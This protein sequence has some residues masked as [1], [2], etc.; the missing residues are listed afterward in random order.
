MIPLRRAAPFALVAWLPA[1]EFRIPR[2]C[3][4]PPE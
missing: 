4:K 2:L 1:V 3:Q